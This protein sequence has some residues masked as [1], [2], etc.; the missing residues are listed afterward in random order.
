MSIDINNLLTLPPAERKL[1]A[2]KLWSSLD[3]VSTIS[4]EDEET[5]K[6]LEKRWD[7]LTKG[8]SKSYTSTELRMMIEAER[9]NNRK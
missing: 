8:K 1:I 5:I 9:K 7:N 6:L 3:P 2:E 4:K